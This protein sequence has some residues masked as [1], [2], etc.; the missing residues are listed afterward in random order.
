MNRF[1]NLLDSY[2]FLLEELDAWFSGCVERYA[3][4]IACSKGCSACCRGLFDISLLDAAL[5]QA[6]FLELDPV[7]KEAVLGTARRQVGELQEQWPTFQPPY[8]LNRL[9]HEEWQEMPE[10]DQT[11]CLLL[12]EEGQCLV[13]THRPMICRLHGLPNID[14]SGESFSDAFCSLNFTRRDP[15]LVEELRYPFR[16]TFEREFALLEQ[17]AERMLG[18]RSCAFDTFIPSA[19]LIDFSSCSQEC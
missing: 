5:V 19:L 7:I 10:D 2:R 1:Q 6:G 8:I 16:A 4:D 15:L 9:P 11:P 18:I 12:G 3:D 14:S 13:Y 17:F